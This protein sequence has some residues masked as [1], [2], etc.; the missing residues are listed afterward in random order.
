MTISMRLVIRETRVRRDVLQQINVV[1]LNT[2]TGD[3]GDDFPQ[4]DENDGNAG[5]GLL[6]TRGS[7]GTK[8]DGSSL[9]DPSGPSCPLDA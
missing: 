5:T 2:K 7:S 3:S 4:T 1:P 6:G 9:R 8:T